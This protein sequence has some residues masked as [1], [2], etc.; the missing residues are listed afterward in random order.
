MLGSMRSAILKILFI[1]C[2]SVSLE[3]YAKKKIRIEERDPAQFSQPQHSLKSLL[4]SLD[5]LSV[6]QHLAFYELYPETPEGQTALKRAWQLLSG[7]DLPEE[8][9][10]TALPKVDIQA[11]LSL[12]T[13]QSFDPAVKLNQ[14][15]LAL[16]EKI[17]AQLPHHKLRGNT[18]WTKQEVLQLPVEDV[19]LARGLLLFQFDEASNL[20][21]EVRQYEASLDLMALQIKARLNAQSTHEDKI[22]AINRFIFQ[23][24]QFRFPPHS[25]YANDI[26]L[27]TFLPSV[28]DSRQG[29]CLGVSILYLSLAQRLDLPLEII[30][31]PG[32]IYVRYNNG[33][34]I[35]N[36]ETTARGID[37]PSET[38]LGINT[39]HLQ[40]RNIKQVI[41]L[42]FMNQAAVFWSRQDYEK[43]LVLYEKAALF[44]PEDPL[45]KMFMGFNYLFIGKN[46][47]GIRLLKQI[48]HVTFD[49]AVS[50]ETIPEDY[51]NGKIDKDGIKAVFLSVDE[52]RESILKKQKQLEQIVKKYPQY[53]AGLLHLAT[54]WL[55][56]GRTSEAKE[57]L[58]RCHKLD[59]HNCIIEYYL[60]VLCMERL[61]YN[62]AWT[63]LKQAESLVVA[64]GHRPKV[65]QALREELRRVNPEPLP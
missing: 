6:S 14:E 44:L 50:P 20:K 64:R 58:E 35:I 28:L 51:L 59:P 18:I 43:T 29:V 37:P 56:L 17:A 48:R 4:S 10:A 45:L 25:L 7:G 54:T 12:V 30:T 34:N 1:F 23:E 53:R 41:G 62:H 15:Q 60:S 27:Y 11:I 8:K 39:R 5:P 22:R 16:I 40:Q 32:H 47:E 46:N 42:A 31:P 65:L 2:L 3:L 61:D 63:F 55:Q 26:D 21:D 52:T 24:M 49:E 38:Y 57:L 19:D 36:I 9:A 13:R 33:K